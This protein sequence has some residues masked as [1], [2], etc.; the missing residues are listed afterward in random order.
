MEDILESEIESLI[1]ILD[2]L[3]EKIIGENYESTITRDSLI[4]KGIAQRISRILNEKHEKQ[5]T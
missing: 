4:V 5:S 1:S 3:L 2:P